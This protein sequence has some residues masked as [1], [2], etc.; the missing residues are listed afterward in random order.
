M[1]FETMFWK[2]LCQTHYIH[3]IAFFH[4]KVIYF[5]GYQFKIL[6]E[7]INDY[8]MLRAWK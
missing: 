4:L 7:R 3:Y 2:Y 5:V 6:L 8:A 1:Q